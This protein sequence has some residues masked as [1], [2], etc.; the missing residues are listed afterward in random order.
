VKIS[1]LEAIVIVLAI[2]GT[3]Y[4]LMRWVGFPG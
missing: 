3:G 2:I 4:V 1:A